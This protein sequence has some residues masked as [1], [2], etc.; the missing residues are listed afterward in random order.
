MSTSAY[1]I[2]L[3]TDTVSYSEDPH[4]RAQRRLRDRV[5]LKPDVALT[6]HRT[7]AAV[8]WAQLRVRLDKDGPASQ[9]R[10][11]KGIVDATG[12]HGVYVKPLE[13]AEACRV[14]D[15]RIQ[16][17]SRD[18]LV[19]V[20]HALRDRWSTAEVSVSGLEV[21]LDFYSRGADAK[22]RHRLLAVLQRHLWVAPEILA[23]PKGAIRQVRE[24]ANTEPVSIRIEFPQADTDTMWE[25]GVGTVYAGRRGAPVS[26][27]VQN[28][29][30]DR[31]YKNDEGQPSADDLSP[32]RR[33]VRVEITLLE[34]GLASTGYDAFE[35]LLDGRFERLKS[36]FQFLLPSIPAGCPLTSPFLKAQSWRKFTAGGVN[37]HQRMER[38]S[39]LDRRRHRRQHERELHGRARHRAPIGNMGP[40][41]SYCEVN[42][43]VRH[44][45]RSLSSRWCAHTAVPKATPYEGS[46]D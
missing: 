12:A 10:F 4:R 34:E 14:F 25:F 23:E 24:L 11:V 33:R 40:L 36:K 26:Y 18:G 38:E 46:V 35:E 44:A 28:K 17:P 31:R 32:E 43:K 45:L 21:A 29:E 16:D 8:D 41:V 2:K 7:E 42:D 5:V 27:R 3:G 9:A 1:V 15:I 37:I 20:H 19:R 13:R 39:E 6:Q 22:E 30:A